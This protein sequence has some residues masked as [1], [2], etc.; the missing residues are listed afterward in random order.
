MTTKVTDKT[1]DV[2]FLCKEVMRSRVTQPPRFARSRNIL[3]LKGCVNHSM[4]QYIQTTYVCNA[5][6]EENIE[7]VQMLH[8]HKIVDYEMIAFFA[9]LYGKIKLLDWLCTTNYKS[10][11]MLDPNIS[12]QS[13][14]KKNMSLLVWVIEKGVPFIPNA[15]QLAIQYGWNDGLAKIVSDAIGWKWHSQTMRCALRSSSVDDILWLLDHGCPWTSEDTQSAAENDRIDVLETLLYLREDINVC[16]DRNITY[17]ILLAARHYLDT[18]D[19]PNMLIWA[20]KRYGWS[21]EAFLPLVSDYPIEYIDWAIEKGCPFHMNGNGT[22]YTASLIETC[23]QNERMDILN[24]L[25]ERGSTCNI[26]AMVNRHMKSIEKS[27]NNKKW[28]VVINKKNHIDPS[29]PFTMEDLPRLCQ[30]KLRKANKEEKNRILEEVMAYYNGDFK[31]YSINYFVRNYD[32][33][34]ISDLY[35]NYDLDE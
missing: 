14:C 6:H 18:Y 5:L 26:D 27:D 21:N 10:Y 11:I 33:E 8:E 17:Y 30:M 4:K 13:L 34:D 24:V 31:R 3:P 22:M 16:F 23:V 29:L 19:V 15:T 20:C 2:M 1:I 25:K 12:F 32:F 9:S 35:D 7:L 28:N